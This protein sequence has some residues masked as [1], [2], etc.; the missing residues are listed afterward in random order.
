MAISITFD[1][2]LAKKKVDYELVKHRRTNSSLD[3]S[4][5]AHLP[6]AQVA[7][8]IVLQSNEGDYLM[9]TL[10]VGHRLSISQVNKLTGKEYH[11]LNEVHLGDIFTDCEQ[12]AIP[13]IGSA[14]KMNMMVDDVLLNAD[15]VYIEAGDHQNLVKINHQ[16]YTKLMEATPHGNISGANIGTPKWAEHLSSEWSLS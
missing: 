9:A 6:T 8:A 3:S 4:N 5:S 2:Y 7:K 14:Y 16:Q 12:G 11:L 10:S 1:E 13:A 15:H